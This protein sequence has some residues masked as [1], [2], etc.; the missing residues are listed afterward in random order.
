MQA[1]FSPDSKFMRVMSRVGDL[2]MLNLVFLLTCIPVITIGAASS[3]LYAVCFRFGTDK[4]GRLFRTYFHAFGE[5]L[6]RGT[7][8]WLIILVCGAAA[9]ANTCVFYLMPGGIRWAFVLFAI[10]FV[11]ILLI[12]AY[13]FPLISQFTSGIGATFRNALILSLGY[14]PRSVLI[15]LFNVFP[16]VLLLTDFYRF[17]QMGF[18]WVALYFATAAYVNSI[19]LKKIFAPFIEEKQEE[20]ESPL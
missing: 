13:I 1:L 14:L 16:F 18:L 4:E 7:I 19:F 12:H 3:A 20:E 2:L 9:G 5:E 15:T 17:L 8:L 6:K 10:L 11:L